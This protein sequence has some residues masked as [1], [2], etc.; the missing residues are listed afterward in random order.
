MGFDNAADLN[1]GTGGFNGGYGY[2][3]GYLPSG[4]N[5]S[6]IALD[7]SVKSDGASSLRFTVPSN[8]GGAASGSFFL[9]FT[10]PASGYQV[11]PG[12]DVYIQWRNRF[13][14]DQ[15]NTMYW[16]ELSG[17]STLTLGATSGTGCQRDIEQQ[18]LAEFFQC[19][20]ATYL[21]EFRLG[22]CGEYWGR[23]G[24]FGDRFSPMQ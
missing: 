20:R 16:G 3:Y 17:Q 1:F 23:C 10:D 19:A 9:N 7:S 8:S 18:Q 12:Q 13:S 4:A 14:Q 5:Y 24:Y 21:H 11:G 2:N 22:T 15:I 6:N